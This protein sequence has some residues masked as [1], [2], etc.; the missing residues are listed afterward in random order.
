MR[1]FSSSSPCSSCFFTE[2]D[3][4]SDNRSV[5]FLT[6][7]RKVLSRLGFRLD[8]AIAPRSRSAGPVQQLHA[9][10]SGLY[11]RDPD[12]STVAPLKIAPQAR[13][14]RSTSTAERGLCD[15]CSSWYEITATKSPH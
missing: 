3:S 12:G 5:I 1:S 2:P 14:R 8:S 11:H 10:L 6:D 9:N 7:S 15:R 13:Q 4:P